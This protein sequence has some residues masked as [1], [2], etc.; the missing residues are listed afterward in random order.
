[1]KPYS[2]GKFPGGSLKCG[3]DEK[4]GRDNWCHVSKNRLIDWSTDVPCTKTENY[5]YPMA[6]PC[7]MLKVTSRKSDINY[8]P[9]E[10][11]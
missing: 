11:T 2:H 4:I 5:G 10:N 7:I 1:L 3:W 8:I 9:T 6:Q